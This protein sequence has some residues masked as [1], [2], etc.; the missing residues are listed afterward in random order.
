MTQTRG[1]VQTSCRFPYRL[2]VKTIGIQTRSS[3]YSPVQSSS[4]K[5]C[6]NSRD[7][8]KRISFY[9]FVNISLLSMG[10]N[11]GDIDQELIVGFCVQ[12]LDPYYI[13][14]KTLRKQT[15]SLCKLL[16]IVPYRI[17]VKTVGAQSVDAYKFYAYHSQGRSYDGGGSKT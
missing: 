10:Y 14:V 6:Y 9:A 16:C 12:I 4:S 5:M 3:V 8:D 11:K 1:A 13:C 15:R 17:C 7:I 2:C